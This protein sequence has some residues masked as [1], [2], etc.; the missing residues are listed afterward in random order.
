MCACVSPCVFAYDG[1]VREREREKWGCT[2]AQAFVS[3]T[4]PQASTIL[5]LHHCE[6]TVID[7]VSVCVCAYV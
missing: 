3:G 7:C 4:E 6:A 2:H 5:H 1:C